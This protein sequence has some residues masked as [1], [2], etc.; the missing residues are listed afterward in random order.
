MIV[1]SLPTPTS[2]VLDGTFTLTA[3]AWSFAD[4]ARAS[5]SGPAGTSSVPQTAGS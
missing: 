1:A 4:A 2:V 3:A 5:S